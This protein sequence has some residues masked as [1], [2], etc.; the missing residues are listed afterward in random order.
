[1]RQAV[2]EVLLLEG[3]PREPSLDR[4]EF[5]QATSLRMLASSPCTKVHFLTIVLLLDDGDE[6][7]LL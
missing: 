5:W 6:I 7:I 1:M 2:A 3:K 4:S